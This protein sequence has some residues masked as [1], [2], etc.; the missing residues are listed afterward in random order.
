M[1]LAFRRKKKEIA[2]MSPTVMQELC[3]VLNPYD[4]LYLLINLC[5]G[6]FNQTYSLQAN[7]IIF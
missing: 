7:Q 1:Y 5:T 2:F 6:G 3:L 4:L